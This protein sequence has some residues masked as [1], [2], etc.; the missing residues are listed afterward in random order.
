MKTV[1]HANPFRKEHQTVSDEHLQRLLAF[2]TEEGNRDSEYQTQLPSPPVINLYR[3]ECEKARRD[4]DRQLKI[5]AAATV[6]SVLLTTLIIALSLRYVSAHLTELLHLPAA[7]QFL[8]VWSR[9]GQG[10]G[11]LLMTAAAFTAVGSLI[12]AVLMVRH[13]DQLTFLRDNP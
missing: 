6:I 9:Y 1:S 12:C 5:T 10:V 4:S 13:K 11:M 8:Q 7:A 3:L 2:M